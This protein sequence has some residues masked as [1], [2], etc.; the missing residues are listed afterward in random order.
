MLGHGAACVSQSNEISHAINPRA[1]TSSTSRTGVVQTNG[2]ISKHGLH[3]LRTLGSGAA[4]HGADESKF[5]GDNF[6]KWWQFCVQQHFCRNSRREHRWLSNHIHR[7]W[8]RIG[9]ND[10]Q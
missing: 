4:G 7:W 2:L 10:L 8:D 5:C 9:I 3:S 1:D 6:A